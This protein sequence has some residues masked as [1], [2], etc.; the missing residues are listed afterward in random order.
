[1]CFRTQ[2]YSTW[3][4][5]FSSAA[6]VIYFLRTRHGYASLPEAINARFGALACISFMM[7]IT[8]RLYQEIWSN[9]TV[10]ASFYGEY[11]TVEWWMAAILSTIIPLGYVTLG[12]M[13]S[14]LTS[15][16]L[17]VRDRAH[18]PCFLSRH[19]KDAG[20]EMQLL[21]VQSVRTAILLLTL[22]C[23]AAR[24]SWPSSCWWWCWARSEPR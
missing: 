9:S 20:S 24:R 14:S 23:G 2:A 18:A 4:L 16:A 11:G 19:T 7:A 1:M 10:V 8:Y 3:Y 6:I 22:C 21:C 15:D 12:G 5:S 17:Q 13:R